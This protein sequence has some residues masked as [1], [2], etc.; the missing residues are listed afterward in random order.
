MLIRFSIRRLASLFDLMNVSDSQC[1][2]AGMGRLAHCLADEKLEIM[3]P[4]QVAPSIKTVAE[5]WHPEQNAAE[6][7]KL[8]SS[9]PG[10]CYFLRLCRVHMAKMAP[11]SLIHNFKALKSSSLDCK[12]CKI[13]NLA[14]STEPPCPP[15]SYETAAYH[16]VSVLPEHFGIRPEDM[17]VDYKM[18]S[19]RG[20]S[21]DIFLPAVNLCIM[22]DGEGH[23]RDHRESTVLDQQAIDDRFNRN[24]IKKR[25]KVLRLHHKDSGIYNHIVKVAVQRCFQGIYG[26][27]DFSKSY[28]ADVRKAWKL[29]LL[30][31]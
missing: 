1:V 26:Q 14:R 13:F 6:L 30:R 3:L 22:I 25:T 12:P 27:I 19:L 20:S 9:H 17:L 31:D 4:G 7:N 29:P 24:A 23:F 8:H 21:I 15:S 10:Q 16:A 2:L 5:F 18:P 28:G 11:K